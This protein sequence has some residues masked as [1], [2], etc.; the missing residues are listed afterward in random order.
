MLDKAC[1][2]FKPKTIKLEGGVEHDRINKENQNT[3]KIW[4]YKKI[5]GERL[6]VAPR[7]PPN[8]MSENISRYETQ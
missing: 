5:S 7:N 1:K 8:L 4:T 6:R 2:T 3:R